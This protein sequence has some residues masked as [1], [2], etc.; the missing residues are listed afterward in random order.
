[1]VVLWL[2]RNFLPRRDDSCCLMC[3]VSMVVMYSCSYVVN[4]Y[5]LWISKVKSDRT[6][7]LL[8]VVSWE[9]QFNKCLGV[10]RWCRIQLGTCIGTL[11]QH[12]AIELVCILH[13]L[14][15]IFSAWAWEVEISWYEGDVDCWCAFR[16][17]WEIVTWTS[18]NHT[19]QC[20]W[21]HQFLGESENTLQTWHNMN[22]TNVCGD[23]TV[24]YMMR[25][26]TMC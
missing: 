11:E 5:M 13:F 23:V 10:T 18:N 9:S 21:S 4:N 12:F 8:L 15:A 20:P 22:Q 25:K 2:I 3:S 24:M 7:T 1:M 14:A 26:I 16:S 6:S 19:L 17:L